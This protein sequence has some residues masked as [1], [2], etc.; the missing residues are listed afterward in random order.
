MRI[1]IINWQDI[2]NPL[3]GGAEVHLHE[4]FSR[5]ARMGHDVTLY[6]SSFHGALSEENLDGI[7]VIRKG[8]R[9]LFNFQVP[10]GYHSRFKR[11]KFDIVIDDMN[12]I[13][14]F[15]PLFVKEPVYG[16]AHHLFGKSIFLETNLVIGSYVY[17]MERAAI[18]LY[19]RRKI[20]FM[21]VSPSTQQ[22]M[23][24]H[25]FPLSDLPIVSNCVDHNVYRKTG[26]PKNPTPLIGYFGRLKKYKSVDH[27]LRALPDVLRQVPDLR[28]IVIGEGDDRPRLEALVRELG[29]Q[30]V[31]EF[32]G[33][34]S[35]ERKVELLQQMWLKVAPSS[36]EGWGLTVLEAN[37]CG[38]PVVASNVPGLRDAVKDNETGLLFPYGDVLALS[39][40]TTLLLKDEKLRNRLTQN[41]IQ[42]SNEFDWEVVAKAALRLLE[43]RMKHSSGGS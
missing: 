35:Q 31:V 25:G 14:F 15:T 18:S 21:V 8:G 34:V 11:E 29:L 6:C 38:T 10:L 41:A 42:W 13:P 33:F 23:L 32:T 36:K 4:I 17:Q 22:E 37:A 27:L 20:P 1:L 16:I 40:T 7:R 26:I 5:I 3:G 9:H 28:L 39:R 24:D 43:N 30:N 12:K 2:K 19:R